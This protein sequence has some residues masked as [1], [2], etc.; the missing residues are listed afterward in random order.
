MMGSVKKMSE[1]IRSGLEARLPKLRKTVIEKLSLA[2]GAML[3]CQ[4]PN[5]IELAN[6][7]PLETER[8]DMREQWLRR[9]LKNP[10]LNRTEVI[11]PFAR[12]ELS[13]ASSNGQTICLCMDQSDLGHKMALLMVSVRISGRALPLAWKAQAGAANIGFEGQKELLEQVRSSLPPE[14]QV[15]LLADRFYPSFELFKW[16]QCHQWSYRLRLKGNILADPG[17]GCETTTGKLAKEATLRLLP[18]VR[19]FARGV[20]T[21]LGI[22]HEPGHPAPWIIAMDTW[23]TRAAI[24]D[25][26]ER[27]GT[28]PMFS[29]FKSR[30]FDLQQTQ[31]RHPDR[32]ERLVLIMALAMY[33]CVHIGRHDAAAHPSSLEKKTREQTDPDHWTHRKL[34]RSMLSWFKRGLRL[35]MRYLQH[36]LPLPP[37]GLEKVI[38]G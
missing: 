35:V 20:M 8:Q 23:P 38:G 3:E 13:A 19:V 29:D 31:L 11:A 33:W 9:L 37:F 16:L 24:I 27:W 28:E 5:T 14:A 18:N 15:L 2:I 1:Q 4:T 30:G 22:L 6:V 34:Y 21:H 25:Y 32:L 10:L 12:L 26:R 7:L 36:D 17:F